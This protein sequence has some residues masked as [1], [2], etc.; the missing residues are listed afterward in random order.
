MR[1]TEGNLFAAMRLTLPEHREM[2]ERLEREASRRRAPEWTEDRWSEIE[3]VLGE[4]VGTGSRVRISLF[5]PYE[6][7]VWEGV[8][9]L[10]NGRVYLEA[11]DGAGRRAVPLE[12]VVAI[13]KLGMAGR[14]PSRAE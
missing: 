1:I 14:E 10:R 2:V 9:V 13:E 5:G 7:E 3:Y 12:R 4:A 11:G 8:P 6:D